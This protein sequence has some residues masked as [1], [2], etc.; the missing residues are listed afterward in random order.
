MIR[1][2]WILLLLMGI[3][4]TCGAQEKALRPAQDTEFIGYWRI[5]LIPD[6]KSNLKIQNRETGFSDPCQVLVH[7]AD[8]GWF[9]ITISNL[10]GDEASRRQCDALKKKDVDASPA[11]L[12]ARNRFTWKRATPQVFEVEDVT[13]K[14][15]RYWLADYVT[16]DTS[17]PNYFDFKLGDLV[18]SMALPTGDG[19]VA[20]AWRMV[21]RPI[22]E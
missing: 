17:A 8:G 20:I 15:K 6:E 22:P 1:I 14:A 10:A 16:K 18:M 19:R 9:N 4:A 11:L 21:L 13:S 5:M 2:K 3:A 12:G 7:K